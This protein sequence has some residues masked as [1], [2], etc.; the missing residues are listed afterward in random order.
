MIP[1]ETSAPA[2]VDASPKTEPKPEAQQPAG[3]VTASDVPANA[4]QS[5]TE[6]VRT[7]LKEG[8]EDELAAMHADCV[9]DSETRVRII[10]FKRRFSGT[11]FEVLE[12]EPDADKRNVKRAY[13]RLSKEFHP[14]RYFGKDLG[15]FA[16]WLTE[17]FKLIS[18]AFKVIGNNKK[19]A[20]YE[21]K[22][23][24]ATAKKPQ[25][26][27]EHAEALFLKACDSELHGDSEQALKLFAACVRMDVQPRYLRR[28]AMCAVQAQQLSVA[29]EYAKK[30]AELCSRDASYLRVLADVYRAGAQYEKA[31]R[32]LDEALKLDTENDVLF[33]ELQADLAAVVATIAEESEKQKS[34]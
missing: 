9:L 16:P 1:G 15:P 26:K 19:R 27:K 33:G 8:T 13:F 20:E 14:D 25:T 22:L 24:G 32:V 11:Y 28:A 17:A 23:R 6:E 3:N 12:I 4:G 2:I 21:S 34:R 7:I 18:T 5:K 10:E 31:L 30:G 29:E